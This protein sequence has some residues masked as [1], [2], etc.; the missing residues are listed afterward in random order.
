MRYKYFGKTGERVSVLGYGTMRLP[1][2]KGDYATIDETTAM[3]LVL[4]ALDRG[5]NYLDTGWPYHGGVFRNG[6]F[7]E[8]G[9]SEL[10]VGK[11]LKEVGRH[12]VYVADKLPTWLIREPGDMDAYLERQ[13]TRLA[14]DHIDFYLLHNPVRP[15]WQRLT[16]LGVGDFLERA[17]RAGKI[18]YAGFSFHDT[19]Q[20]FGEMTNYYAFDFCQHAINYYDV[21]FQA[22]LASMRKAAR[23]GMG[24]VAMEPLMAGMLGRHLPDAARG[25][26]A[27][28]HTPDARGMGLALGVGPAGS[29]PAY[30]GHAHP[31]TGGGEC[32]PCLHA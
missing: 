28:R 26:S 13:L 11:V 5:V 6:D 30:F 14:T 19:P 3:R 29:Q 12:K 24:I 25:I 4:Y 17:K 21:N 18:R 9:A 10:F 23:R 22:G 32:P 16:E 7:N 2:L 8:G 31:R 27:I 1:V 15:L 20:L